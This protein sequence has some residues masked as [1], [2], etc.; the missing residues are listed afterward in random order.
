MRRPQRLGDPLEHPSREHS[1]REDQHLV[2][3]RSGRLAHV[4][5][6]RLARVAKLAGAPRAAAAGLDLHVRAGDDVA[7]DQPLYTIHAESTG[8]LAY[9]LD[10]VLRQRDILVVADA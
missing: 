6:R 2:P 3:L 8:E 7:R 1:K 4:D 5:N 10:Y 9:A